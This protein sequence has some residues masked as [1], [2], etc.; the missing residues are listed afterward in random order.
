MDLFHRIGEATIIDFADPRS[1]AKLK[2]IPENQVATPEPQGPP[3]PQGLVEIVP[4]PPRSHSLG[5]IPGT[6]SEPLS[7][8]TVPSIVVDGNN[9]DD[10]FPNL[11]LAPGNR[12]NAPSVVSGLSFASA[13][14]SA[15]TL[16]SASF[17]SSGTSAAQSHI[18]YNQL[19]SERKRKINNF[20]GALK[21]DLRNKI[22]KYY[23]DWQKG[24]MIILS[25]ISIY[26]N[27]RRGTFY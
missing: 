14:T 21:L 19:D 15:T 6:P 3:E 24:K 23:K 10:R 13:M 25:S 9:L 2:S 12:P 7:D 17:S 16:S 27:R 20:K 26:H 5:V 8:Q 1:S 4:V 18:T 11:S 22:Q